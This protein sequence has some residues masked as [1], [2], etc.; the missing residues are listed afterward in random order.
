MIVRTAVPA[1]DV[2][3]YQVWRSSSATAGFAQVGTPTGTTFTVGSLKRHTTY[4]F[5]VRGVDTSGNIG[6][7]SA[8]V[9]ARTS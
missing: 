2:N 1:D 9:A 3:N 7:F 6:T 8:T 5:R 4:H